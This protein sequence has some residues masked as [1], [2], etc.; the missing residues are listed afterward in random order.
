VRFRLAQQGSIEVRAISSHEFIRYVC[1][2]VSL[3]YRKWDS[4]ILHTFH[5]PSVDS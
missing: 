5:S 3:P 1:N 2:E 4:E